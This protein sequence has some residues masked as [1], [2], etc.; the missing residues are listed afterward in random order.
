MLV[1]Q[2]KKNAINSLIALKQKKTTSAGWPFIQDRCPP[3][4][5]HLYPTP[6]AGH[7]QC[8]S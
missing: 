1:S 8:L 6:S 3:H 2:E 5:A 4:L 7:A